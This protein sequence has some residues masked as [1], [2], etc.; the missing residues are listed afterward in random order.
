MRIGIRLLISGILFAFRTSVP[1]EN[2]TPHPGSPGSELQGGFVFS[3]TNK[4]G[5]IE[6]K[7]EG[8]AATFLTPTNIEIKNARAIY[9]PEDGTNVVATS[10]KALLNKERKLVTTDEF[11]TIVTENSITTGTGLEW[12]QASGKASLKKDV[13]VIYTQPGGKGLMR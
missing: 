10:A 11:V 12:Y 5:R 8:S 4:N 9:Y 13:K 7:I 1:A 2:A 3:S 6:W